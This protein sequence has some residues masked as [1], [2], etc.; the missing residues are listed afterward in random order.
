MKPSGPPTKAP[1]G[2]PVDRM[3]REGD[4]ETKRVRRPPLGGRR[5]LRE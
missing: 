3:I 5:R 4:A 1:A 2:P